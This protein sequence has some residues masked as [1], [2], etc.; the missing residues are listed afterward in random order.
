MREARWLKTFEFP[1]QKTDLKQGKILERAERGLSYM[2]FR[3]QITIDRQIVEVIIR[4][5]CFSQILFSKKNKQKTKNKTLGEL[6][7]SMREPGE[8]CRG[9]QGPWWE[10]TPQAERGTNKE[11]G[12]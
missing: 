5:D 2:K 6:A 11:R 1:K 9:L 10:Q 3:S 4:E 12:S 7:G 8:V